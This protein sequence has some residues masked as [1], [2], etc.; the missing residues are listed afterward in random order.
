[1]SHRPAASFCLG[2]YCALGIVDVVAELAAPRLA[3][4]IPILLMPLLGAY[5]LAAAP[6][7]RLVRF[8]L[9]AL[10]FSWLGDALGWVIE[11]KVGLF[12]V[13]QIAYC[14]AFWPFRR[15]GILASPR[16]IGGYV[17]LVGPSLALMAAHSDGLWLAVAVYG[18]ML[19]LMVALA[20][21]MTWMSGVGAA[22]F[23]LSDLV[24]AYYILVPTPRLAG[25]VIMAT[26]LTAQLLI[27][28]AVARHARRAPSAGSVSPEL[29]PLS[30]A[31]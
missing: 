10:G 5:L 13:A 4:L 30:P 6:D 31:R 15:S 16:R 11:L 9:V 24:V 25:A 28:L 18:C 20:S 17:L 29:R 2:A 23:M 21:G 22:L 26:Y 7:T 8:V 27:V 3:A 19:S 12:L 14:V 1:M